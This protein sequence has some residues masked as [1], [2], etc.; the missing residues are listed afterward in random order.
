M[1]EETRPSRRRGILADTRFLVFT[2]GQGV[3]AIGDGIYIVAL[4]WTALNLTHSAVYLGLLLT[5]TALPRAILM[6]GGGVLVDR[7][8][9]RR[10]ILGSD[11]SRAGVIGVLAVLL[12]L[13]HSSILGLFVVA[14]IFGVFDA[15]FYPAA[16]TIMP[17]LIQE[18][19]LS[20]ANG[21]WQMVVEGSLIVGPP[22][23]G[24]IVGLAG[25]ALAFTV[26]AV[27]FLIAFGAL[28]VIRAGGRTPAEAAAGAAPEE[29]AE[30]FRSQLTA[31]LRAFMAQPFLR[32][33]LPI[34]AAVNLAAGG[35]LNVGIPLLARAHHWG[36]TGFGLLFGG[37]GVGMLVGGL[38]MSAGLK[39]PRIGVSVMVLVLVQAAMMGLLGVD[40]WLPVSIALCA[41]M[42]ALMSAANISIISLVQVI[43]PPQ[44]LGRVISVLMFASVSLTPIS[45]A[46]SGGLAHG[47][48]IPGLFL[49]G[50]GLEVM[51]ALVALGSGAVRGYGQLAP[52][53]G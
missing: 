30:S 47:I 45:Y 43:S 17:R 40:G 3:S 36:A 33:L 9:A 29:S 14:G 8:G 15:L 5:T 51:A 13:G 25:P 7:W 41:A 50:A 46:I 16:S 27:T 37:L 20:A 2:S 12:W 31:G 24:V 34:A 10:V 32:A 21:V 4:A 6:L 23:G 53:P 48:G 18:E 35:P 26:D 28:L 1:A 49:A 39:L 38:A 42:G 19:H 44:L 52:A 11:L 22:L